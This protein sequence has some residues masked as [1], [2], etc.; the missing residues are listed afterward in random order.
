ML[1]RSAAAAESRPN[2]IYLHSHDTGRYIQPYGADV[3]TP[4]LQ[5]LASEGVLFRNA[6]D[7]A[8]TCSP[9]RASLLT[10]HCPHSN[11][12]LGLA[13]RG[14]S[15]KN[16]KE[17]LL[18]TLRPHGYSSTL[19]GIQHIA[20]DPSVIGYDEIL[21]E[22]VAAMRPTR[23][24]DTGT[25]A[26]KFLER[27]P[28][29]PFFLDIGF[30]ETHR[31]FPQPTAAEDERFCMPPIGV[32]DTPGTRRDMAGFKASARRLD[33]AIGHILTKLETTGLAKNT[34]VIAT[35]DHGVAFPNMK[36]N[37]TG[38]G[39]GVYLIM[40]GPGGFSGG[41]INE[42]LV[43][44]LDIYPTVCDLLGIEKPAWLQG[45]SLMPVVRGEAAEVHD[46]IYAEVNYHA[47]YEPKRST[48]THRW[49][50]IRRYGD[51]NRPVLPN[52]DDSP[53]KDVWLNNG[54]R[55]HLLPREELYDLVFD[56]NESH[57]LAADPAHSKAL[58]AMQKRMD[59]WMQRTDDPLLHGPV[60]APVGAILNDP[61]GTSPKDLPRRT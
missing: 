59:A 23:L 28:K 12:M 5:K 22:P 54:W 25:T 8:P 33:C 50:Y 2:I 38:H 34:L 55:D 31:E 52:C 45:K 51:R 29:Q 18:H 30:F 10:G 9:S 35:T 39:T 43:S 49:N 56:P 40:R 4:N 17:H 36:C 6:F 3:P 14:F 19:I 13:H 11:G 27:Q 7:V 61:D 16:Y 58:A 20:N 24:Y 26:E 15:L 1:T 60:P 21:P 37:L 48:R 46:E 47:A 53:C 57:N 32:P 44:Q 42:A 41:K